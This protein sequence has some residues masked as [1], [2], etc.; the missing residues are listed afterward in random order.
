M[1]GIIMSTQTRLSADKKVMILREHLENQVPVSELSEKYEIHPN[2]IYKWKKALFESASEILSGK[3]K[4]R[5][6]AKRS[7][8]NKIEELETILHKREALITEI[9]E[10][11]MI[12]RK[13][14]RGLI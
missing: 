9:V 14:S 12:L 10:D 7:E 2:A 4:P 5:T 13:K 3:H 6:T 11:N 8:I 1:K